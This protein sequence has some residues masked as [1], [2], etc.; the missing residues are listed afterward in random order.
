[1]ETS[2]AY[3]RTYKHSPLEDRLVPWVAEERILKGDNKNTYL[4]AVGGTHKGESPY[5]NE[6]YMTLSGALWVFSGSYFYRADTEQQ[7]S[8]IC[9]H[10]LLIPR[11]S[12]PPQ[13][14]WLI[15]DKNQIFAEDNQTIQL[16][17]PK[18]PIRQCPI[19]YNEEMPSSTPKNAQGWKVGDIIYSR[20]GYEQTNADFAVVTA[21]TE[22]SIW[23]VNLYNAELPSN[24]GGYAIPNQ[25]HYQLIMGAVKAVEKQEKN[26]RVGKMARINK[27]DGIAFHDM[28]FWGWDGRPKPFNKR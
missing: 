11:T 24:D 21:R 19:F 15:M 8:V 17:L 23:A 9:P 3:L 18:D 12:T 5:E 25:T 10:D 6:G 27:A 2:T 26:R 14:G 20:K 13:D 7:S 16:Q 28:Y 4:L 22:K 1:M